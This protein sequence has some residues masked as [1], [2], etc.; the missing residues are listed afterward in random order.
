VHLL[1]KE[2]DSGKRLDDLDREYQSE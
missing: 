1:K 2:L